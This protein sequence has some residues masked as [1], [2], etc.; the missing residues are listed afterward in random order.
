MYTLKNST[1]KKGI[2]LFTVLVLITLLLGMQSCDS[3]ED[4]P[5]IN[6]P[7]YL[8]Y[9]ENA[10][11][12]I[13]K[14]S[15]YEDESA[16]LTVEIYDPV[17]NT[18]DLRPLILLTHGG[19]LV[20]RTQVSQIRELAQNLAKRGYVTGYYTY[21]TLGQTPKGWVRSVVDSKIVVKYFKKNAQLYKIDPTNIFTGG[22]S[23]GAQ[24]AMNSAHM[25]QQDLEEMNQDFLKNLLLPEVETQGFEGNVHMNFNADVKGT[26]LMLPYTNDINIFDENGP[27]VMMIASPRQQFNSGQIL[28]DTVF[29]SGIYSYGPDLMENRLKEV[30]YV[31]G[32]DLEL[33]VVPEDC[34]GNTHPNESILEAVLSSE[35]YKND[36]A[37]FFFNN[38]D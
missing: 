19:G 15:Y 10:K 4:T 3:D 11:L 5:D 32:K 12:N 1:E 33:I 31:E 23:N 16:E 27:A 25:S 36:I 2:N 9:D 29:E 14:A 17:S 30:G 8:K 34:C 28:W 20:N 7:D 37:Q 35:E 22:W 18:D 24:T 6:P 21:S 26:L 13:T 38:L